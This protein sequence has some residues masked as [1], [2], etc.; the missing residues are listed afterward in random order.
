MHGFAIMKLIE[1]FEVNRQLEEQKLKVQKAE[2]AIIDATVIESKARPRRVLEVS[3]DRKEL[4]ELSS[5]E[6]NSEELSAT[7]YVE[8]KI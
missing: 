8:V 3:K 5:D 6:I 7:N 2:A 1:L 4:L